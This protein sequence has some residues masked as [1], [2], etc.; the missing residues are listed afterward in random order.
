[1]PDKNSMEPQKDATMCQAQERCP[2]LRSCRREQPRYNHHAARRCFSELDRHLG[3]IGGLRYLQLSNFEFQSA[4]RESPYKFMQPGP[5]ALSES[6]PLPL[7]GIVDQ[8]IGKSADRPL[9]RSV[10]VLLNKLPNRFWRDVRRER[11]VCE[12]LWPLLLADALPC[13]PLGPVR[14]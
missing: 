5:V 1:M 9:C 8:N 12:D 2:E 7:T 14:I 11:C 6:L 4:D 10:V 13:W 3:S